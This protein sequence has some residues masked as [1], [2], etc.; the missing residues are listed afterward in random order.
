M[1]KTT[2]DRNLKKYVV[3][4]TFCSKQTSVQAKYVLTNEL[5]Y[6]YR[7]IYRAVSIQVLLMEFDDVHGV[8]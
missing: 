3:K 8:N 2:V 4:L 5:N 7:L 6:S 1:K